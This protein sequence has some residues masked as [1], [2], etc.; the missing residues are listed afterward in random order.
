MYFFIKCRHRCG[1]LTQT[2]CRREVRNGFWG[3]MVIVVLFI[4]VDSCTPPSLTP[5]VHLALPLIGRG[6]RKKSRDGCV[7]SVLCVPFGN[8]QCRISTP[9][10][11]MIFP[12]SLSCFLVSRPPPLR[13]PCLT[14]V[15][16]T[17]SP[18][19]RPRPAV[20]ASFSTAWDLST[21]EGR[22]EV[23]GQLMDRVYGPVP[24]SV[25]GG[26]IGWKPKV[27]EENKARY[28]WTDAFGVVNFLSLACETGQLRCA[29]A[30]RGF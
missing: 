16:A 20:M 8:I 9:P 12:S 4:C 26:V 30:R 17:I 5:D 27:L 22:V 3:E 11:C 13:Y 24:P 25:H 29:G 7:R 6:K 18:G 14:P 21:H 1:N 19:P 15:L 2:D 10:L 23:A 28:L